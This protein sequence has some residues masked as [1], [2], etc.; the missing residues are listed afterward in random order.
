MIKLKHLMDAVEKDDGTRIWI[1]PVGLTSDLKEW[2]EVDHVLCHLG[3]PMGLWEWFGEHPDGYEYFRG[4]YHEWLGK[5]R[6]KPALRKLACAGQKENITLLYQGDDPA[7]NTA[8]ALY[9]FLMELESY[10]SP[11]GE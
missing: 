9:E 6:Y 3:P 7:H 11:D 4:T 5:S 2:C 1:E 8:T 10:C